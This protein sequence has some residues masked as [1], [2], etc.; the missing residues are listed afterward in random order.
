MAS[1]C[2][3]LQAMKLAEY[4]PVINVTNLPEN[5][6]TVEDTSSAAERFFQSIR[7]KVV[8][9]EDLVM[10]PEVGI[11]SISCS[12]LSFVILVFYRS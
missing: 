10:N 7:M 2:W 8:Y 3:L 5:L 1:I 4:K 6:Q 12:F 9:Y 11:S